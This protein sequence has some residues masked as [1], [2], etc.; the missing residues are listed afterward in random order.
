MSTEMNSTDWATLASVATALGTLVLA[1]AT[2]SAIRS[3]NRS[4]KV[5]ERALLAGLRPILMPTRREDP[6]QKVNFG[7]N[8]W[9]SLLGAAAG[10]EIGDG[11]T[12]GGTEGVV[13]LGFP[14]RNAGAGIAVLHGWIFYPEWRRTETH[15][16]PSE[17]RHQN[18][19]LYVP[20]GDT[21]FW[22]AA[23]R[24]END[25]QYKTARQA[26]ET[27]QPW[28]VELLYG[29]HEGGQRVITR[30]TALPREDGG[31]L[32]S[33]SRHWN[34]DRPEPREKGQLPL[35]TAYHRMVKAGCS[36]CGAAPGTDH[37]SQENPS[38]VTLRI[39]CSDQLCSGRSGTVAPC[40]SQLSIG[41][42]AGKPGKK[43]TPGRS[44]G[45]CGHAG[46]R[47]GTRVAAS[48]PG[49]RVRPAG[50]R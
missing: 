17:F 7:D 29:D 31:W 23:F 49:S 28:T 22:Q 48:P 11:T 9:M 24:D 25:P 35:A 12:K 34:I 41:M 46:D 32:A 45:P 27:R 18:R 14:L 16:D 37:D 33:S 44:E 30:F 1:A 50:W 6:A 10:A 43:R 19:D 40:P 39:A 26:V 21:G 4:A 8:K 3:A 2:F 36:Y 13:Y 38:S 15:P 42:R 5:A 20:P 47:G